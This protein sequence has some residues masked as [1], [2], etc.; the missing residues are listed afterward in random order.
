[1]KTTGLWTCPHVYTLTLACA[2]SICSRWALACLSFSSRSACRAAQQEANPSFFSS[3]A[4][5]TRCSSSLCL[6]CSIFISWIRYVREEESGVGGGVTGPNKQWWRKE[7]IWGE[8]RFK[9]RKWKKKSNPQGW[10]WNE[11]VNSGQTLLWEAPAWAP[12]WPRSPVPYDWARMARCWP[13][14]TDTCCKSR[15]HAG[16]GAS[17]SA[18]MTGS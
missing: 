15:S 2:A 1:M 3:R 7:R 5:T 12:Y 18:L 16:T 11:Y 9:L 8:K 14:H 13:V 10:G 4:C 17:L 6:L